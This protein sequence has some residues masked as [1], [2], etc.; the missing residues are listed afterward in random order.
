MK[1]VRIHE[2]GGPE[3]LRYEDCPSPTPGPG[4][5]LIEVEAIGVNFADVST[6]SGSYPPASLPT[7]PGIE[8]AGVVSAVGDDV[9]DVNIGDRVAYWGVMGSYTQQV[10]I[11]ANLLVKIPEGLDTRTGAAVMVQGM[12]AHYLAY[13]IYSLKPGDSVLVHAGAGGTGLLLIQMAKRAGAFV[14]ATVSTDEKAALAREFGADMA[15]NYTRENFEDEVKKAT[16]GRGVQVVYDSVGRTTFDKSLKCLARRGYL[17][18]YGQSSG[19]VP[20]IDTASLA[21]GS[22]F[23]TRP[24]LFDYTADREDLLRRAGEVL[25]WVSSGELKLRIGGTFPLADAA[26]AHRQLE[27]RE[28]TGKLLLIP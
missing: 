19:P 27:G 22:V 26:E 16:D 3:V 7:T 20:P 9:T 23:L 14:F 1:A 21:R 18:L 10:A 5:A 25:G 24:S 11:P 4:Q 17:A 8:A 2:L 6:R 12:T 15:I 13:G 28:S